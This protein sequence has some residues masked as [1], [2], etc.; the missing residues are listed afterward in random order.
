MIVTL[1]PTT[2][3]G[4]RLSLRPTNRAFLTISHNV[5][6]IPIL[7][8]QNLFSLLSSSFSSLQYQHLQSK[9]FAI[10][11]SNSFPNIL[12][13][14][15]LNT[16][17]NESMPNLSRFTP[18]LPLITRAAAGPLLRS[19]HQDGSRARVYAS[20]ISRSLDGNSAMGPY[21]NFQEA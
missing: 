15:L 12:I 9:T 16:Y 4:S 11:I 19:D 17:S 1:I 13:Q 10:Y 5:S 18:F 20:A 3:F 6:I 14:S 7:T 2:P 8:S 21:V